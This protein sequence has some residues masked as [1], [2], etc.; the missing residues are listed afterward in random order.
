MFA[1]GTIPFDPSTV[2][3]SDAL[4]TMRFPE[5][6]AVKVEEVSKYVDVEAKVSLLATTSPAMRRAGE[7]QAG[8]GGV[9]NIRWSLVACE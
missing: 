2:Y 8:G 4:R 3:V 5:T 6:D 1:G 9:A 7:T